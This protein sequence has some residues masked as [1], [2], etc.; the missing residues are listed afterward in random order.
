MPRG[1]GL[2]VEFVQNG[3]VVLGQDFADGT[4]RIGRASN[5]E[6]RLTSTRVSK[7]HALLVVKGDRAAIVDLGSSN[8]VFVNGVLIKKQ[9]IE[10]GDDVRVGDFRVRVA[11]P[12]AALR[13][14]PRSRAGE[15]VGGVSGN[16][17]YATSP[18]EEPAAAELNPQEKFLN[19]I[20]QKVL[21]PFYGA[22]TTW[23]WRW[24]L[25]AILMASLVLSVL[26][27]VIPV[28]RWGKIATTREALNRAHAI[29]GQTVRENYRILSKTNDFTRLTV[30]AAE[31]EVGMLSV[32]VI[33]PKT[34]GILAPTKLFN[35]SVTDVY[36]LL[37]LK[38]ILDGKEEM[39]SVEQ[40][41]N[42]YIVA[43]PIYLFSQ[44]ANDRVLQAVVAG[45]FQVTTGITSTYEPLVEASLFAVLVSL[46]AFFLIYK[47]VVYP[48]AQLQEQLDAA[49]KGEDVTIS[50]DV[51]FP[52]LQ[53]LAQVMNFSISRMRSG[54][55]SMAM[56]A[57]AVAEDG[58]REDAEYLKTVE[59]FNQ[60]SS[61]ALLLLDRD[62]KVCFVGGILEDLIGMRNQYAKG[63]NISDA[64][65]DQAFAGTAID[66]AER[67]ITSLGDSQ[68]AFLDIN[69]TARNVSA[70]GHKN[71]VGEIRFVLITVK[72]G[73]V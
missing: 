38:K 19:L 54:G 60:G 55:G 9:R 56:A 53:G 40:D 3:Q 69:G 51:K 72:M 34:K 63:Q 23:D 22:M 10:A 59:E 64:C 32:F 44:E 21:V 11:P 8:G 33:D 18:S 46:A 71:S 57:P 13:T 25:G 41:S 70:V 6:V 7:E 5:C 14:P 31:S 17:A 16:L 4:Y 61:D 47:M 28:V 2:R 37:A 43:Q 24:I 42:T 50:S 52:E 45:V 27:S 62:K 39:V 15:A 35:K 1:L 68:T 29:I 36:T 67:V 48:I 12:G 73:T 30:E 49:L 58:D 26:L 66:M 65:R 20:D